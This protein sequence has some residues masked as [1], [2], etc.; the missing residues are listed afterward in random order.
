M[1]NL[2]LKPSQRLL[3]TP[4]L[5]VSLE[6]LQKPA[7]ELLQMLKQEVQEN[8]VIEFQ[9]EHE[10]LE[11][12]VDKISL[13][14]E[15]IKDP[16]ASDFDEKDSWEAF[17]A[18]PVTLKEHLLWQAQQVFSERDYEIAAGI[19]SNIAEDGLLKVSPEELSSGLGVPVTE[20]ERVR[21][22]IMQLDPIGVGAR[23]VKEALLAQ[24][25]AFGN[26]AEVARSLIE[27]DW[28]LLIKGEREKLI[29]KYGRRNFEEAISIISSLEPYPGN[30]FSRANVTYIVPDVVIEK[31]DGEWQVDVLRDFSSRLNIRKD[32]LK[33]LQDPSIDQ[34]TRKFLREKLRKA[35]E[36][37]RAVEN[38]EET[39]KKVALAILEFQKEFFEKG[40]A[41]LKPLTLKEIAQKVGFHEATISRAVSG[42]YVQTPFG[43]FE[44]KFFFKASPFGD[45]SVEDVKK[46]I[47]EIIE[48]EKRPLSDSQIA[49]IL[50]LRGVKIAR[51]TVAKYR[52]ELGIPSYKERAGGFKK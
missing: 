10:S 40:P 11:S 4:Q 24:L 28:E 12:I 22:K 3:I 38:R 32:Y 50:N 36:L 34:E 15:F 16:D 7:L 37:K 30:M 18:S 23:N 49:K 51:R 19:I 13:G 27:K 29:E 5:R 2:E 48:N 33:L 43:V 42:K 31:R 46:M 47:K 17:V 20:V 26:N 25:D 44:M 41:A 35:L 8:P 21:K 6:I 14:E 1:L 9:E 45:K 52:E 39:L